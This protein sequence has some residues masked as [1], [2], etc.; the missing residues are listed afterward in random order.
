[1]T[2]VYWLSVEPDVTVVWIS[3]CLNQ[4]GKKDTYEMVVQHMDQDEEG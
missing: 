2:E 1:M 4:K 3:V